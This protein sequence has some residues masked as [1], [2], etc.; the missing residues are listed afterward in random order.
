MDET[1]TPDYLGDQPSFDY[2]VEM[3]DGCE[4]GLD[5]DDDMDWEDIVIPHATVPNAPEV[6]EVNLENITDTT[7]RAPIQITIERHP[8]KKSDEEAK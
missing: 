7:T 3:E 6:N 1:N 2:D 4:E 8:Q 5:S